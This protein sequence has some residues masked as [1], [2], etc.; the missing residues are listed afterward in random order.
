MPFAEENNKGNMV[1]NIN[2]K[3]SYTNRFVSKSVSR[4]WLVT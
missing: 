4:G 3:F 2:I 1:G